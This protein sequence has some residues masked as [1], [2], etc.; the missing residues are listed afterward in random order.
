M[1]VVVSYSVVPLAVGDDDDPEPSYRA[2]FDACEGVPGSGFTDVF[3]SHPNAGDIDC[4]AFYGI[5]KGTSAINYSPSS[6][7]TRQQMALSLFRLAGV[8]GIEM[9]ASLDQTGC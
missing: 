9:N 5:A 2:T 7:V 1:V 4:V 6:P 8:V 3:R